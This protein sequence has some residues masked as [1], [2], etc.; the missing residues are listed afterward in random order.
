MCLLE[1]AAETANAF[2]FCD[3]D[4]VWIPEKLAWAWEWVSSQPSD[5]PAIY[6]A[7]QQITDASLRPIGLSPAFRRS[8]GF[9]NA[10][11]QNIAAGC[12]I[13]INAAAR[14][15]VLA[16]PSPP[17][18]TMHDWWCY[19]LVSGA[20][21]NIFADPRPVILYR[22][23]DSNSIG[24]AGS[25]F[26]RTFGVLQRGIAP[27]IAILDAHLKVLVLADHILSADARETV[28]LLSPVFSLPTVMRLRTLLM[29][30][31]YRQTLIEDL[32]LLS[33][34]MFGIKNS[35]DH[36]CKKHEYLLPPQ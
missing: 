17:L 25:I 19:L 12:T 21:G 22:Q 11:V 30:R 28:V 16:A 35:F 29:A 3:Q 33:F 27:F 7:R 31:L 26:Y 32:A 5:Q 36:V 6:F 18:G 23:H 10:L 2:A 8:P 9:R 20:G 14:R 4:D 24:A 13:M 1:A 34:F 15:L